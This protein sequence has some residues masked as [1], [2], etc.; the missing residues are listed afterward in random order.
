MICHIRG[1]GDHVESKVT[2]QVLKV[3]LQPPWHFLPLSLFPFCGDYRSRFLF[4]Y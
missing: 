3:F 2:E 1:E 4:V